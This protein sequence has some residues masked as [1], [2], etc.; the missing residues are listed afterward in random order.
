MGN[1]NLQVLI[2]E[3]LNKREAKR[4]SNS[5]L[6]EKIMSF[7]KMNMGSRVCF[8]GEV[9]RKDVPVARKEEEQ[10]IRGNNKKISIFVMEEDYS[11][12]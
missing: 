4:E 11:S 8:E 10:I 3:H 7:K 6:N 5:K 1:R 12:S 2:A 9:V